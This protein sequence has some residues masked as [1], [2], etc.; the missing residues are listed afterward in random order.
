MKGGT[1]VSDLHNIR[2][3]PPLEREYEGWVVRGIEDYFASVEIGAQVFALGWLER[4]W[5]ADE[6]VKIPGKIV[7]L[8]FKRADLRPNTQIGQQGPQDVYW[9]LAKTKGQLD[10]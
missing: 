10:W 4:R 8:Q 7:G 5:K 6:V 3:L 9:D 2:F 1:A